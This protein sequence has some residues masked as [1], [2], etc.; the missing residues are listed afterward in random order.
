MGRHLTEDE[1]T[2]EADTYLARESH[3]T[4]EH[5]L[6]HALATRQPLD[7]DLTTI[8]GLDSTQTGVMATEGAGWFRKT[9]AA[10]KSAMSFTK[11]DVGLGNVDDTSDANKPVSA[12]TQ[13]AL[14]LKANISSLPKKYHGTGTTSG[15]VTFNISSGG[16]T[17]ITQSHIRARINDSNNSYSYEVTA[18]SNTSVTLLVKQRQFAGVTVL[19]IGVLGSTS[20]ANVANGTTVYLS[21]WE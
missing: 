3:V 18:L 14:D 7:D 20:M 2:H 1:V 21:I 19:G 6:H 9:Y 15:S 11:S 4:S 12:A 16:F 13:S 5:A 10:L 8:A 17:G